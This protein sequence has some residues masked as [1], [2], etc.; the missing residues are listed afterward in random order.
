MRTIRFLALIALALAAS[1]GVT[2]AQNKKDKVKAEEVKV[3]VSDKEVKVKGKEKTLSTEQAITGRWALSGFLADGIPPRSFMGGENFPKGTV[4]LFG[5]D[6]HGITQYKGKRI[7]NFNWKASGDK[8]KIEY[9]VLNP[10]TSDTKMVRDDY[11]I[12]EL[13]VSQLVIGTTFDKEVVARLK[14]QT[15]IKKVKLD[16]SSN[17]IL[18]FDAVN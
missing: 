10:Q 8:L 4:F 17:L 5:R 3:K 13:T 15:E 9:V 16:L 12:L 6:G 2:Q 7:S 18:A 11:S 1:Y 14:G